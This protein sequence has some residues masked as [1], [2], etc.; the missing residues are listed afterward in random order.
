[1]RTTT[2]LTAGLTGTFLLLSSTPAQERKPGA[3]AVPARALRL[4]AAGNRAAPS[5]EELTRR[6]AETKILAGRGDMV[7]SLH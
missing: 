2:I 7:G 4:T 3:K 6:F 5:Q 1:M